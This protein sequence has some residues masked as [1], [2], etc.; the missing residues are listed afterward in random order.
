MSE[1]RR[2]VVKFLEKEIKTY[3]A[4]CLFFSKTGKKGHLAGDKSILISPTYYKDRMMEAKRLVSDL[5]KS[6]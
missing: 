2:H 3:R 1:T 4:L 6:N 5:K